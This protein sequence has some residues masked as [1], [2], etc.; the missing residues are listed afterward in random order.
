MLLVDDRAENLVAREAVLSSLTQILVPVR[1]GEQA[2]QALRTKEFAVVLLDIVMPGMNGFETAARIKQN[3][4]TRDVPI[5]FLT[6]AG[7]QPEQPFL[8]YAV[9][10][11]DYL[12]KPFD[13]DMLKAK[14]SV[15][16]D[17]YLKAS[18]LR[19]QAELLE[20][21]EGTM[22]ER[23][24][25]P[26]AEGGGGVQGHLPADRDVRIGVAVV[27]VG[28][29]DVRAGE[30]VVLD[31]QRVVRH[32]V[33]APADHAAVPDP[34]HRHRAEVLA[35]HHP[36]GQGHEGADEGAL[37]D[38]DPAFAED[39]TG[40][41]G[42]HRAAAERGEPPPGRG[43]RGQHAGPLRRLP[44]PVHRPPPQPPE[45]GAGHQGPSSG[46]GRGGQLAAGAVELAAPGVA[47]RDRP[48][49]P[50]QASADTR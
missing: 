44:A 6:A 46:P 17:L 12:A 16:V 8:S 37:A 14:V 28:D 9:G 15:F 38:R 24:Q 35:G 40:R 39:R 34:Q 11:A 10:A 19:E 42:R 1:S 36:R 4:K 23:R 30:H 5:I 32:D 41:E 33:A 2:L 3:A 13:P 43:V 7:A 22:P 29:V 26:G 18:Q 31:H 47:P 21:V 49:V 48:A 50:R 25:V 20:A 27:L 45:P